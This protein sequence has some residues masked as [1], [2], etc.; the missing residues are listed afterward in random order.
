MSEESLIPGS[1]SAM[2]FPEDWQAAIE[3][4][5]VTRAMQQ[6]YSELA[7]S[8]LLSTFLRWQGFEERL[9]ADPGFLVKVAIEVGIGIGTKTTAEATKRGAAFYSELDFVFANLLMALVADFCLVWLPAPTVSW[10]SETDTATSALKRSAVWE[11]VQSCPDNCFQ[12]V[13]PSSE[14]FTIGQRVG[15]L[16]VNGAKLLA[17]GTVASLV[18]VGIINTII[19]ARHNLDPGWVPL[20]PPQNILQTSVAYGV[21]MAVSS[22]L[23]YQLIAGIVEERGIEVWFKSPRVRGACSF[24][25]RTLNTFVGSLLWL[26][27]V[28]LLG[29]QTAAP[30]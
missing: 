16:A 17:V 2:V 15:A 20:N 27:F 29:M 21:Y 25:V 13:Q 19:I 3:S 14:T 23:R 12:K 30:H 7:A 24:V 11:F 10:R 1:D 18:G 22:N 9:L 28:R 8:R 4:G 26:D 6:R 5:K